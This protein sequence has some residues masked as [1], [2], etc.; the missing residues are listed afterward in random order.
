MQ[1]VLSKPFP[2]SHL[3]IKILKKEAETICEKYCDA[4]QPWE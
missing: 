4:N 1:D 2:L 3:E